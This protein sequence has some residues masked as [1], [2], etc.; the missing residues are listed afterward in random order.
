[1]LDRDGDGV[2]SIEEC[3]PAPG[4]GGP[5][6]GGPGRS[7]L[8]PIF[9]ALDINGD[10]KIDATEIAQAP[11]SLLKLDR[12]GDGKISLDEC[13]P[14]GASG[15][16]GGP[17]G[18]PSGPGGPGGSGIAPP[19]PPI[20]MIFGPDRDGMISAAAIARAPELLLK[21]D[22]NGDGKLTADEYLPGIGS[23]GNASLP[24]PPIVIA[25]DANGDGIID[26]KEIAGASA[27]LAKLVKNGDGKISL[28]KFVPSSPDGSE[29]ALHGGLVRAERF[30]ADY[31]AFKGRNLTPLDDSKPSPQANR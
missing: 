17:L 11:S 28:D 18:G 20:V 31:P 15:G 12:N 3:I 10:G 5:S 21:L 2:L 9:T 14:A 25:L 30:P 7:P 13:L 6:G 27:A 26:A 8:P 19:L 16:P 23:R 24:M 1:M 4:E 22:R 29:A